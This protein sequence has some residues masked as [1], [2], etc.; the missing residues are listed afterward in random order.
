MMVIMSYVN[1]AAYVKCETSKRTGRGKT[2]VSSGADII[3]GPS[4]HAFYKKI[5][6]EFTRHLKYAPSDGELRFTR[7]NDNDDLHVAALGRTAP[8]PSTF[9]HVYH[10]KEEDMST[11][12]PSQD[13]LGKLRSRVESS[14]V[15]E[16]ISLPESEIRSTILEL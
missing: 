14:M 3:S 8:V 4:K 16:A 12:M 6:E 5:T 2:R 7:E 10:G 13:T 15:N 1:P 11:I 9:R